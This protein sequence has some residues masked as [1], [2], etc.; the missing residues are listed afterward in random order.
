MEDGGEMV[1]EEE[2][3]E[4]SDCILNERGSLKQLHLAKHDV[5]VVFSAFMPLRGTKLGGLPLG[6]RALFQAFGGGLVGGTSTRANHFLSSLLTAV[7][8]FV[9]VLMRFE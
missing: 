1:S 7:G 5:E 8:G 6:P 2:E 9:Q 3:E 4:D